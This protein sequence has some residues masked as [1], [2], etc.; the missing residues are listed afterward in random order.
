MFCV[1]CGAPETGAATCQK[2]GTPYADGPH[3]AYHAPGAHTGLKV[4]PTNC[5]RRDGHVSRNC[6]ITLLDDHIAVSSGTPSSVALTDVVGVRVDTSYNGETYGGTRWLI[7]SLRT[8]EVGFM[9]KPDA[10]TAWANALTSHVPI[11]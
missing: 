10:A 11:R 4:G 6:S 5:R 7:F 9:M 1:Q 3:A 2:C 8:Q